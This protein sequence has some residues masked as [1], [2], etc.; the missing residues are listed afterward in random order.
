MGLPPNI[1]D[2]VPLAD[3]RG[4]VNRELRK[5]QKQ[6]DQLAAANPFNNASINNSGITVTTQDNTRVMKLGVLNAAGDRGLAVSPGGNVWVYHETANKV[7]AYIGSLSDITTKPQTGV[8][9]QYV[10]PASGE[11]KV[12]LALADYSAS[13]P[14]RQ[15]LALYDNDQ[16]T[17]FSADQ[18]GSGIGAPTFTYGPFESATPPTDTT[19]SS[20]FETLQ[21]AYGRKWNPDYL[22][23]VLVQSNGTAVGQVQLTDYFGTVIGAPQT[24]NSGDF[25]YLSFS[26]AMSGG[27]GDFVTVNIQACMTGGS[28]SIGVRGVYLGGEGT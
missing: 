12:A 22:A 7:V 21:T 9:F 28:G 18:A 27:I 8:Q 23:Q 14:L 20:S 3:P 4:W 15:F 16:A 24:V 10:D 2:G 25:D 11:V 26:G 6:I 17:I 1:G 13:G 19:S 5:L